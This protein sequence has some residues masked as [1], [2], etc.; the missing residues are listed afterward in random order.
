MEIFLK[1]AK[2]LIMPVV[3]ACVFALNV[4]T[5]QAACF[6]VCDNFAPCPSGYS[7]YTNQMLPWPWSPY[8][9]ACF[10]CG[11]YCWL[12]GG[13]HAAG[14]VCATGPYSGCIDIGP[15]CT[16]YAFVCNGECD[17]AH[18]KCKVGNLINLGN[19]PNDAGW[20]WDCGGVNGGFTDHCSETNCAPNTCVGQTCT[21]PSGV[22]PG[23]KQPDWKVVCSKSDVTCTQEDCESTIPRWSYDCKKVDQ[24]CGLGEIACND[25]DWEICRQMDRGTQTCGACP[26]NDGGW[27]EVKPD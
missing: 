24:A 21:N 25:S 7:V 11:G 10:P 14:P 13:G 1:N 16:H 8:G 18:F 26:R 3:L 27:K 12:P 4:G 6:W 19:L 9:W 15:Y 22:V 20:Y 5:I 23:T 17:P 2:N